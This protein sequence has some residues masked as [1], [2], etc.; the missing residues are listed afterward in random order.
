MLIR[1]M[2]YYK[3]QNDFDVMLVSFSDQLIHVLIASEACINFPVITDIVTI[4]VLRG[5]KYRTEPEHIDPKVL[6]VGE[7]FNNTPKI[8]EDVSIGVLIL[9]VYAIPKRERRILRIMTPMIRTVMLMFFFFS[10]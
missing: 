4:V 9:K 10:R 7:F 1:C 8:A 5:V 2:V 6:K 3:I